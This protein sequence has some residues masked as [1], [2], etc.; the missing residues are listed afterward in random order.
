MHFVDEVTITVKAG[1]GGDGCMSF[2]REKFIPLGGPD[3]GDGGKGG[4]IYLQASEGLNTLSSFRF[5][6]L[7]KADPGQPGMGSDCIGRS[8]EDL[9]ISVPVGT[10]VHDESTGEVIGDLLEAGSQLLV[11]RGG[12]RGLGN[13][14]FKSSTNRA[15]RHTRPGMPGDDRAIRLQLKVLADVGL[16]GMPN[17]GKSTFIR[18]VSNAEPKVAAYPF[19]TLQPNLGVVDFDPVHS[20]VVAD[21]PGLIEGAAEG[22]G[23][24][25]QFL[26]HL[27]RTRILLHIVDVAPFDG[28]DPV[29]A[30]VSIVDELKRYDEA[31]YQKPRWLVLNKQDLLSEEAFTEVRDA[32]V[33]ALNWQGPIY[34]ISAIKKE[35]T[36]V[37]CQDLLKVIFND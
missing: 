36:Q 8:G 35:G 19:T 2:R 7:H 1:K 3:G 23:L 16:L 10:E 31:L 6:R 33:S 34:T 29:A 37:I 13:A 26:K 24:G 21:I 14:H 4:D 32:I 15:P 17:A 9:I 25:T 22:Q 5:K 12:Q 18:A 20:F 30:S 28:S 11:A 27:S